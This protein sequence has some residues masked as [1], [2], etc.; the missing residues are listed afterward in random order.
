V[1]AHLR[2]A[3]RELAAGRSTIDV[4]AD[5]EAKGMTSKEAEEVVGRIVCTECGGPMQ[6]DGCPSCG[7][8]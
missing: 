1:R 7:T 6:S 3:E 8:D 4:I 5:L 2:Y